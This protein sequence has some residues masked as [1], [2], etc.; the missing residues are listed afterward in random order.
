MEGSKLLQTLIVEL[1][2]LFTEHLNRE[3]LFIKK[4]YI[5]TYLYLLSM[6]A[7]SPAYVCTLLK[8]FYII[9]TCILFIHLYMYIM[10]L[11]SMLGL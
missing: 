6:H 9:Q 2:V 11:S 7:C 3:I 8:Y 1:Y 4:L 5:H 10:N